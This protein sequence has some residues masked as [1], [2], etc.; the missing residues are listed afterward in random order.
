MS[1]AR[2]KSKDDYFS[3]HSGLAERVLAVKPPK[4]GRKRAV[5]SAIPATLLRVHFCKTGESFE[6][7]GQ[8]R[9]RKGEYPLDDALRS[10][11][12]GEATVLV[13]PLSN[14]GE[15]AFTVVRFNISE[16]MDLP[17]SKARQYA[18]ELLHYG[19]PSLIEVA[20]GGKGHYHLWIFHEEPTP[21][22]QFSEALIRLGKKVFGI[23]LE[24]VPSVRGEEYIPLPLQGESILLQ[25]RVFVN[26]VGK[27][28]KDQG[29]VLQNIES[30]S[31]DRA[32]EFIVAMGKAVQPAVSPPKPVVLP[33]KEPIPPAITPPSEGAT[34]PIE[35]TVAPADHSPVPEEVA[36]APAV[37]SP[38]P[39]EMKA[40]GETA[41]VPERETTEKD[42]TPVESVSR[43]F[44]EER[45][46]SPKDE[47]SGE[48]FEKSWVK[49]KVPGEKGLEPKPPKETPSRV[50][51]APAEQGDS[52]SAT[53]GTPEKAS[54][55]T[56]FLFFSRSG[57]HYAVEAGN[58]E[59][60]AGMA[61]LTRLPGADERYGTVEFGGR[62]ITVLDPA[63]FFGTTGNALAERGRIIALGGDWRGY[64]FLADRIT[65]PAAV[66]PGPAASAGNERYSRGSITHPEGIQSL[67][68]DVEKMISRQ[69]PE[70]KVPAP[71][72]AGPSGR[73]VVFAFSERYYGIP[74]NAVREVLPGGKAYSGEVKMTP[75]GILPYA[76]APSTVAPKRERVLVLASGASAAGIPV[77]SV[78]GI[79]DIPSTA[80]E[81]VTEHPAGGAPV[82]AVAHLAGDEKRVFILDAGRLLAQ[83]R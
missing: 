61:D 29:N 21:A 52:L 51:T 19:V 80:L 70:K 36:P 8:G 45:G 18:D 31:K 74:V 53:E 15:T 73:Y 41:P 64:G 11:L 82:V 40:S 54:R 48:A 71:V 26:A 46:G 7:E 83:V 62:M 59:R 35:A 68:L 75:A 63:G 39:A 77:D 42:D 78:R 2:F 30:C 3:K 72:P 32:L 50:K 4:P 17:F 58:V 55:S 12:N 76:G 24:T 23:L 6:I 25:R 60:I 81:P 16:E 5:E 9:F 66:I 38:L 44:K 10:H 37:K 28:I 34:V 43:V 49:G 47:A 14:S 33:E 22:W 69:T 65:G 20:E 1:A 79:R 67:L 57:A 56:V 27:M 13:N